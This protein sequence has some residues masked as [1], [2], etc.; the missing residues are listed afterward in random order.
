M[1]WIF[2]DGAVVSQVARR[3]LELP[4]ESL[5]R[6]SVGDTILNL[7]PRFASDQSLLLFYPHH[8][9]VVGSAV[10]EP[11]KANGNQEKGG[12]CEG[13]SSDAKSAGSEK[14]GMTVTGQAGK[15]NM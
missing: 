9:F 3:G 15:K 2:L 4:A 11:R 14:G 8:W 6:A 10:A 5:L 1:A 12:G 13:K 7:L